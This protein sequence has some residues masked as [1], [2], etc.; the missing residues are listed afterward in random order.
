MTERELYTNDYKLDA[1]SFVVEQEHIRSEVARMLEDSQRSIER[2]VKEFQK[3]FDF[4]VFRSYRCRCE[5]LQDILRYITTLY[6]TVR[7]YSHL[8]TEVQINIRRI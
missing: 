2:W 1:I 5:T 7:L 4:Q 6:N 8:I 3:N